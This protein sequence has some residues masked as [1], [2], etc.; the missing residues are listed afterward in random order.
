MYENMEG[1]VLQ[2]APEGVIISEG[3]FYEDSKG[4]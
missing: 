4:G 1:G 2:Q 3:N